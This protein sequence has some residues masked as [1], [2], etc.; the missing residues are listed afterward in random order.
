MNEQINNV[1]AWSSTALMFTD[2][3]YP[4]KKMLL[5]RVGIEPTLPHIRPRISCQAQ[6]RLLVLQTSS[7]LVF[8]SVRS[9]LLGA[10]PCARDPRC[11][12]DL[13]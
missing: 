13:W 4:K 2:Y 11:K 7:L 1:A 8:A 9:R 12:K 3:K 5:Q 6:R 10:D